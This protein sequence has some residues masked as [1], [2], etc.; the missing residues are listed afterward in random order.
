[1]IRRPP[2]STR[3]Y[4][5][6]PYTTLFRS[7]FHRTL[8]AERCASLARASDA[9]MQQNRNPASGVCAGLGQRMQLNMWFTEQVRR[10]RP[11]VR[12]DMKVTVTEHSQNGIRTRIPTRPTEWRVSIHVP[13][14]NVCSRI[15]QHLDRFF[16]TESRSTMQTRLTFCS[17]IAHEATRFNGSIGKFDEGGSVLV[18]GSRD[19]AG[20]QVIKKPSLCDRLRFA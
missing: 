10:H 11:P 20:G 8:V 9:G 17:T 15:Q 14:L 19:V 2:R 5:L 4:T 12:P 16:S 18:R 3:R 6:F 13:R 1:M 7:W